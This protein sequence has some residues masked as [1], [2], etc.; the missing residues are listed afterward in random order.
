MYF[1]H[2]ANVFLICLSRPF[3]QHFFVFLLQKQ[4]NISENIFSKFHFMQL[5]EEKL[6]FAIVW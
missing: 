3:F 4:D 5:S 1:Q 2:F 6:N